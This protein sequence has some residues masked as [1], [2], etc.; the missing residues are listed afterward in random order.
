MTLVKPC[1]IGIYDCSSWF[2]FANF[3]YLSNIS[4]MTSD[5]VSPLEDY[6]FFSSVPER[7]S[8]FPQKMPK[9]CFAIRKVH[10]VFEVKQNFSEHWKFIPDAKLLNNFTY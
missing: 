5:N 6:L 9:C 10:S 3:A 2:V 8:H 4:L 1:F 7:E